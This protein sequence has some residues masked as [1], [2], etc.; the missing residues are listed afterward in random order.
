M[1]EKKE[2]KIE[3]KT[4]RQGNMPRCRYKIHATVA[5]VYAERCNR[6]FSSLFL[7][8]AVL[9]LYNVWLCNK[10]QGAGREV[11]KVQEISTRWHEK[12][13]EAEQKQF[14]VISLSFQLTIEPC[15]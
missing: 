14:I 1:M 9:I 3:E 2:N 10:Q 13:K 7:L 6:P 15:G 4:A 8:F 5:F 11:E 12:K